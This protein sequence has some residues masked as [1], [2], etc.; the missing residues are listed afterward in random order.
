MIPI[1]YTVSTTPY[2]LSVISSG[3]A[4]GDGSSV[5]SEGQ[6]YGVLAAALTIAS[7]KEG[8]INYNEAK[9]KFEGYFNGWKQMCQ[10]SNAHAFCQT[11]KYCNE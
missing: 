3:G 1:S 11:P 9:N 4:A 10:N 2:T 7:M 8:D 6:A 5:V